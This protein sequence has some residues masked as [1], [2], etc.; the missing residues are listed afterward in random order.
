MPSV[1]LKHLV[2]ILSYPKISTQTKILNCLF[3][4]ERVTMEQN[5]SAT[6]Q[7]IQTRINSA[8]SISDPINALAQYT[9][10]ATF[11]ESLLIDGVE[12]VR[13]GGKQ[14][15]VSSELEKAKRKIETTKEDIRNR[16][17][18]PESEDSMCKSFSPVV[19]EQGRRECRDWFDTV[20]G[21]ERPK[22]ELQDGLINTLKYP[23]LFGEPTKGILL[24]GPP[25]T[26]KTNITRAA[27]NE[28][29][30]SGN[31]RILFYAPSASQ[32]KGK[33][34][35]ESEKMITAMFS[36]ASK[37]ACD[38]GKELNSDLSK[39]TVEVLSVIF[40]DELDSI[41]GNRSDDKFAATTVN[42]LLQ[43]M[44]GIVS[45]PNVAMIGATNYPW[46]LDPAVLRRFTTTILVDLPSK[47]D[48]Y[49][50]MMSLL[51]T[52]FESLQK[53]TDVRALMR[54]CEALGKPSTS[55]TVGLPC[56]RPGKRTEFWRL[57]P[58]NAFIRNLSEPKLRAIAEICE[59]E[60]YSGADIARLF[61]NVVQQ[62]ATQA[63]ENNTFILQ[64]FPIKATQRTGA[65]ISTLSLGPNDLLKSF[66]KK[67]TDFRFL[68]IPDALLIKF[69][70]KAFLNKSV[71]PILNLNDP[72]ISSVFLETVKEKEFPRTLTVISSFISEV[73]QRNESPLPQIDPALYKGRKKVPSLKKQQRIL[74]KII[75]EHLIS[76][77]SDMST[78][79]DMPFYEISRI[80]DDAK[81]LSYLQL[82]VIPGMERI[83][84]FY[85]ATEIQLSPTTTQRILDFSK[86]AWAKLSGGE[87]NPEEQKKEFSNLTKL[88]SSGNSS[89]ITTWGAEEKTAIEYPVA[90]ANILFSFLLK[91]VLD[92]PVPVFS[93]DMGQ[94][95][96]W[97][98]GVTPE[99]IG[100]TGTLQREQEKAALVNFDIIK[101][102]PI[103]LTKLME[104]KLSCDS[105]EKFYQKLSGED[106]RKL[107]QWFDSSRK[108]AVTDEEV[109]DSLDIGERTGERNCLQETKLQYARYSASTRRALERSVI[110]FNITDKQFEEAKKNVVSTVDKTSVEN[111]RR[112]AKSPS[113]FVLSEKK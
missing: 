113:T 64:T 103:T 84:E 95:F 44:D 53:T 83:E 7:K 35:G 62:A 45:Y 70:D 30:S 102:S 100:I 98:S 50:Q 108:G 109:L 91:R 38:L 57:P 3:V 13:I 72:N 107:D 93:M 111:L 23:K 47:E 96:S 8:E 76:K 39:G 71:Y 68:N 58:Y 105:V 101:T 92:L 61:K 85:V 82:L 43:V 54:F 17:V 20:I 1:F 112:Y 33:Y 9:A 63:V 12:T 28:L 41:A 69:A 27:I 49:D 52:H 18:A 22:K 25:G 32:L 46:S 31:I 15:S 104:G 106:Q 55:K 11:L 34:F 6:L 81:I 75:E 21:L 26:G 97:L 65:L 89:L 79:R 51:S 14:T 37:A 19:F 40:L 86:A 42:A 90:D 48:I 60:N 36:C 5:I 94:I 10:L 80:I 56:K 4:L 2:G 88:L 29:S 66:K 110:N 74:Y 24:Y 78:L 73:R 87:Y 59:K 99:A 77:G 16:Y 67:R